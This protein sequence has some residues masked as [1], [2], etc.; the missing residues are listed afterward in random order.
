MVEPALRLS[1]LY[2]VFNTYEDA[3]NKASEQADCNGAPLLTLALDAQ[4]HLLQI[5]K[6]DLE[7][8]MDEDEGVGD[9]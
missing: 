3:L 4:L 9:E 5:L 8:A 1:L 2:E 6:A 7:R